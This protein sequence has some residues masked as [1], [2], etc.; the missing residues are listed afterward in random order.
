MM[1][2]F[3][4][5]SRDFAQRGILNFINYNDM[6]NSEKYKYLINEITE[7]VRYPQTSNFT[8]SIL[9]FRDYL[10]RLFTWKKILKNDFKLIKSQEFHNL[11]LDL[12]PI[13]INELVSEEKIISDLKEFNIFI[14]SGRFYD[15]LFVYLYINWE[16]FQSHVEISEYNLPNPYEPCLK[17]IKRVKNIYSHNGVFEI[18]NISFKNLEKYYSYT[19]PSTDDNFL[20]FIDENYNYK[21]N[22]IPNQEE[23][24]QLWQ[25]FQSLKK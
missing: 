21:I 8:S 11:F 5:K 14:K 12:N 13:W 7:I 19:L 17:I 18:G 2:E 4:S 20:N 9:L 22:K 15:S 23:T 6:I 10:N 25:E 16:L 3:G 24:N 1:S